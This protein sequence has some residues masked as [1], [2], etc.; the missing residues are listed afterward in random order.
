MITVLIC[1]SMAAFLVYFYCLRLILLLSRNSWLSKKFIGH[2]LLGLN[3]STILILFLRGLPLFLG[4]MRPPGVVL[5]IT[6]LYFI[7]EFHDSVE[8]TGESFTDS[9]LTSCALV[10]I[11]SVIPVGII[12]ICKDGFTFRLIWYWIVMSLGFAIMAKSMYWVKK[13]GL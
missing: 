13:D 4:G 11:S 12:S 1:L 3:V 5:I 10:S 8:V 7:L 6:F 2:L 9:V